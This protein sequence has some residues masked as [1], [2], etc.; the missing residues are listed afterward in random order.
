MLAWIAN[1]AAH[2]K[3]TYF[4]VMASFSNLALAPP[5]SAPVPERA[6]EVNA[7]TTASSGS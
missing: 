5:S 4:A 1:P 3:A 6:F 2:L 7:A